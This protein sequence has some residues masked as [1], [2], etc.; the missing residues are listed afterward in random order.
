MMLKM[1]K[2]LDYQQEIIKNQEVEK[3]LLMEKYDSILKDKQN[4]QQ[5]DERLK[6][7]E[8]QKLEIEK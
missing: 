2:T 6:E 5:M 7:L 4:S 1:Q 8:E 3:K